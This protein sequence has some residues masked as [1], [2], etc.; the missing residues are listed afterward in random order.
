[1]LIVCLYVVNVYMVVSRKKK[2][3]L[4]ARDP[5]K[6]IFPECIV[7]V[8]VGCQ[9]IEGFLTESTMGYDKKCYQCLIIVRSD[10]LYVAFLTH[11][12][13]CYIYIYL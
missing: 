11:G 3:T 7:T 4:F 9:H 5:P 8:C 1:M 13:Y 10:P 6:R 12:V 2:N